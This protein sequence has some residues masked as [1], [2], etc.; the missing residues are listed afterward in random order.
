MAWEGENGPGAD[1]TDVAG[2]KRANEKAVQRT[3]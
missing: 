3:L 2:K 1:V